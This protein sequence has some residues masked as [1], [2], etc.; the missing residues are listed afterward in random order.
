MILDVDTITKIV[1]EAAL[2]ADSRSF[3]QLRRIAVS[4]LDLYD[5]VNK[6]KAQLAEDWSIIPLTFAPDEFLRNSI[7]VH[8]VTFAREHK[9]D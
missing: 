2:Y 9:N 4:H 8:Q 7:A 1:Q 3:R 5:E 6:L